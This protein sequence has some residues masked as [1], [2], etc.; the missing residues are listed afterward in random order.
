MSPKLQSRTLSRCTIYTITYSILNIFLEM[1]YIFTS[2]NLFLKEAF[3]TTIN[4][5][6]MSFIKVGI[7]KLCLYDGILFSA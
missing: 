7:D 2:I 3:V 6:A 1:S 5:K 4:K